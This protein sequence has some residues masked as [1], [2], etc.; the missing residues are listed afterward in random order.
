MYSASILGRY[1]S[2][3]LWI[4]NKDLMICL[5]AMVD[6]NMTSSKDLLSTP[7]SF[8]CP[9]HIKLILLCH[10]NP[11]QE[12]GENVKRLME[13]VIWQKVH[14][15]SSNII[16]IIYNKKIVLG[17]AKKPFCIKKVRIFL[18][19]FIFMISRL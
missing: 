7:Q 4:I 14:L 9:V 13:N 16:E 8:F 17:M 19:I 15:I 5:F 11:W 12:L 18:F 1:F 10:L 2:C 6:F 3:W